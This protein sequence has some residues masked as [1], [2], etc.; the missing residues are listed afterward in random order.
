MAASK[1]SAPIVV[2]APRELHI[3][4]FYGDGG[5]KDTDR[6]LED[7]MAAWSSQ[8][9]GTNRERRAILWA[10]LGE[11]VRRELNC[12]LDGETEDP[13][14][15]LDSIRANYGEKRSVS[16]LLGVFQA[17]RQRRSEGVKAFSHRLR[18]AFDD[19]KT[20]QRETGATVVGPRILRD[21]FVES[22]TDHI[23]RRQLRQVVAAE[24]GLSFLELREMAV[25]WE[26][27]PVDDYQE[28]RAAARQ[29][30]AA[31]SNDTLKA[32]AALTEQVAK[33]TTM[34][35]EAP[36]LKPRSP[37]P[38]GPLIC[39]RCQKEGHMARQCPGAGNATPLRK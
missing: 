35:A 3:A 19:L 7:V 37:A 27:D 20:R 38:R 31:E 39:Y 8:R 23:L 9:C 22:L 4:K 1:K 16:K 34:M 14:R 30:Q 18:E 5:A 33:L 17:T 10:H 25:R 32:I 2:M 11:E 26:D 24:P 6:F 28:E 12:L 13:D 15:L 29:V 21:H 36:R